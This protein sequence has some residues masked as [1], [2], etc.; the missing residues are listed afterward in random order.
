MSKPLPPPPVVWKTKECIGRFSRL[1][2]FPDDWKNHSRKLRRK[3]W[4]LMG[5]KYEK[6]LP[7]N[8]KIHKTVIHENITLQAVTYQTR[9]GVYTTATIYLPEGSGP[10]PGV[11]NMHGHWQQGRL[12][13]RVQSRGFTLAKKGYVVISV[14]TF[15]AGERT[16]L[17]TQFEHHGRTLG[18]SVFNLGET[19]MGCQLVDNMRAVDVLCSLP[20]V[21]KK[22]IGATGASGGGNQTMYLAAMDERI[23]AAV[24][25]CSVGSYESYLY[26]PNCCCE[27]L[28]GGLEV[29]EMAGILALAAPRAMLICT[30]LYDVK[31]FSPQEMLRS[32]DAALVIFKKLGASDKFTYRIFNQG[33]A[34]SPE[35]R[36]AMLG[37]FELHLKGKGH[38]MP[39]Q[40][41][42]FTTLPEEK[43][44]AFEPGKRPDEVVSLAAYLQRRSKELCDNLYA[45]KNF[46]KKAEIKKLSNV[47]KLDASLKVKNAVELE[48]DGVWKRFQLELSDGNYLPL[49]ITEGKNE[50][51][52]YS[53]VSGK[54]GIP[55]HDYPENDTT[56]ALIDLAF[57]GELAFDPPER[58]L[59]YHQTA[60]RYM[61][62]GKTLPGR[63]TSELCA[64]SEFLTKKYPGTQIALHGYRETAL[65]S[66]FASIFSDKIS[67]VIL[68]EAPVSYLFKTRS[69]FFGMASFI[70]G[71]LQWGDIPLAC[72]L[73]SAEL[74]WRSPRN[75]DGTEASIPEEQIRFIREKLYL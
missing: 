26:E 74:Q 39:V 61:W 7:L 49:V 45:R 52:L 70:P 48:T 12:A 36:E 35:A 68:E 11:V 38:G 47:L 13:A 69:D 27:T 30:G 4:D 34:Y 75:Q 56:I 58:V 2:A 32:Y 10:F 66:L 28:P 50:I 33:H 31:T 21:D 62:L 42:P 8:L 6:N 29:T 65:V 17:H 59:P 57:Q 46:D 37:F 22:N 60:R 15:G 63:W 3:L 25:V 18:S 71:I 67:R 72:A 55:E 43:L 23:K 20:T 14:D 41:E 51:T 53:S 44:L 54:N 5:V 64:V 24:P 73:T 9:P 40:E 1:T 16:T 19:L